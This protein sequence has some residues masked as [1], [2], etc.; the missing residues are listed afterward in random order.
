MP[1]DFPMPRCKE[2]QG[3]RPTSGIL[4]CNFTLH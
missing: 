2:D 1:M 4:Q 3:C